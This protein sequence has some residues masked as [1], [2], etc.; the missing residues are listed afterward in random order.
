[1]ERNL[2]K[3]KDVLVSKNF[4]VFKWVGHKTGIW[5]GQHRLQNFGKEIKTEMVHTTYPPMISSLV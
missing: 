3:D 4:S 5:E 1:M 2:K